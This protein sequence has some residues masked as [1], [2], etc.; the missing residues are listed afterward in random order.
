MIIGLAL[1]GGGAKGIAH[2]GLIKYLKE[3][4]IKI[5]AVSGTSSGAL[6]AALFA[7]GNDAEKIYEFFK[8]PNLFDVK[9]YAFGRP[10]LIRSEVFEAHIKKY[11]LEDSFESLK[12]PL[13][14]TAVNINSTKLKVF[15]QGELYKPLLASA[16]FPGLFTPVVIDDETYVDGGVI[17]NFPVDLLDDCDYRIGCYVN[18]V[19]KLGSKSLKRSYDVAGRAYAISQY[20]KDASK[21]H[22]ADVLVEPQELYHYGLFSFKSLERMMELGYQAATI[23]LKDE[24]TFLK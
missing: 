23:S 8:T 12:I 24:S 9:K 11:I 5:R 21:F 10:G 3:K 16:A 1:S 18:Q 7:A 13:K 17:N 4:N 22:L 6:V 15:S 14:I 20:S 2:A 19:E